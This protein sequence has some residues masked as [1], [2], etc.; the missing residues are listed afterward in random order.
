M[1]QKTV[2]DHFAFIQNSETIK[3][4][5]SVLSNR[6]LYYFSNERLQ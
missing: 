2:L 4:Q 6:R 3:F 5:L 1:T